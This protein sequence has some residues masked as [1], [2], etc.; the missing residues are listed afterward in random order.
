MRRLLEGAQIVET[1]F[2]KLCVVSAEGL[3]GLKLQ[4]Y[5]NDPRRLQDLADIR[6]LLRANRETLN[7]AE[8]RD[9][10]VAPMQQPLAE[11]GGL[12][13]AVDSARNPYEVLDDLMVAVEAICSEWPPRV[14]SLPDA[15]LIL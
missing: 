7:L 12:Q 10:G 5:V 14:S 11:S 4:G 15:R 1:P 9:A 8:V 3:I 13:A 6:A 2:G